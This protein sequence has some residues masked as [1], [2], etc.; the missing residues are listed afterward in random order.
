M[1]LCPPLFNYYLSFKTWCLGKRQWIGR[2]FLLHISQI[3]VHYNE[4]SIFS[5]INLG[6]LTMRFYTLIYI[7]LTTVLTFLPIQINASI[8]SLNHPVKKVLLVVAMDTEAQPIIDKLHLRPLQHSF[9]GLPMRGYIGREGKIQVL[10]MMNGEDPINHVQNIGKEAAT[11]STYLGIHYFHPD[12]IISIGT[13]GSVPENG[14]ALNDIY[15]NKKI[16]FFDRRIPMKGYQEYGLGGYTSSSLTTIDKTLDLKQGNICSGDSFDEDPIDYKMFLKY[17]C[18]V[19]EMEAAAV[20]WVSMLTKTPMIAIKGI[21]NFVRG[22]EIH[23]QYEKNLPIVTQKLAT[24]LQSL[25]QK[26]QSEQA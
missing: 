23:A 16:Y 19:I 21:T 11:L 12:L 20:G 17:H 25:I 15:I 7:L 10:L 8:P 18:N 5:F 4:H 26:L 13:A 24:T 14:A 2:G 1:S 22:K 9:S 6:T 3:Y